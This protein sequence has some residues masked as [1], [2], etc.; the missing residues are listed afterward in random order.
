MSKRVALP[1]A[2]LALMDLAAHMNNK[3]V[4]HVLLT[5]Y[6]ITAFQQEGHGIH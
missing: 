4:S 1:H 2:L 5:V 3:N 6:Q